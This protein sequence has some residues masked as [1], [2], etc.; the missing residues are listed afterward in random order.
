MTYIFSYL[1][2][3]NPPS[4]LG[5]KNFHVHFVRDKL[6]LSIWTPPCCNDLV[7][8]P[9]VHYNIEVFYLKLKL[10]GNTLA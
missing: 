1:L 4:K 2:I 10:F 7:G 6:L 8:E 5:C 9:Y 3:Y